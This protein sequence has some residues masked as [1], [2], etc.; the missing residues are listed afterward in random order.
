MKKQVK[1]ELYFIWTGNPLY[2]YLMHVRQGKK[3]LY[4]FWDCGG[5]RYI[6]PWLK[7]KGI[8]KITMTTELGWKRQLKGGKNGRCKK[9]R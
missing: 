9:G 4:D 8:T 7:K 2:K 3:F 5:V 6:F 1:V